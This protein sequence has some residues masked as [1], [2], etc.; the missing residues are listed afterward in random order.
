MKT[1]IVPFFLLLITLSSCEDTTY[2]E[3]TGNSPVYMPYEELRNAIKPTAES[4]L[5]NPGKIYFKDNYIFIIEELKGIHVYDNSNPASPVNKAFITVPGVA[6][7]VITDN[8]LYADSYVDIVAIDVQDI[9]NIHETGRLKDILPYTVV[10]PPNNNLQMGPVDKSKGIVID[11]EVA[12]VKERIYSE[13]IVYPVYAANISGTFD[14][15]SSVREYYS[16]GVSSSGVGI[17]GSMARFGIRNNNLY[18]LNKNNLNVLDITSRQNPSKLSEI[19][20]GWGI[21]TM[22]LSGD[23]M[24]LGTTTGMLIYDITN[25]K[26]PFKKSTYNHFRSCD[27][28][29]VDD[30]IAYVTLRTGTG[31]GGN[32]NSLDVV[33]LK[34]ILLPVLVKSYPM[35]NPHG[36]GK[37]GD[38]LFICDGTSGLKVY[39]AS[40][41][42]NISA[43]LIYSYPG[44]KAVDAIPIGNVLVMVASDGLYQYSYSNIRNISLL[45]KIATVK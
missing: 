33:N 30:T 19:N 35:S 26:T 9:N 21:E 32:V 38:L 22:F 36:L 20:L 17:G 3:F 24:Y 18:L 14:V 40:D 6:D 23:Y 5:K 25:P 34:N 13:P 44:I 29:V 8:I 27:P 42:L 16:G 4:D 12:T 1:K 28:V 15:S 43:H 41:P 45:S 10:P 2:R 7:M 37:D 11:W 39:D 31:C